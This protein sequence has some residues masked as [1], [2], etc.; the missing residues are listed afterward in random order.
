MVAAY[1][2]CV[3]CVSE[4]SVAILRGCVRSLW[5]NFSFLEIFRSPFVSPEESIS[6]LI[7]VGTGGEVL[8]C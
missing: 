5:F 4:F 8:D 7:G 3:G 6:V 1:S 2:A